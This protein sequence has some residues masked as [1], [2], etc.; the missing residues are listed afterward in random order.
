M[1][2][3]VE[4]GKM[5]METCDWVTQLETVTLASTERV[6]SEGK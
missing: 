5:G 6:E 3:N 2:A 4:Q 1:E